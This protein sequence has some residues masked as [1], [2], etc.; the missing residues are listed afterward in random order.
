[1]IVGGNFGGKGA[2]AM[3]L[4]VRDA[5][6]ARFPGGTCCVPISQERSRAAY[7]AKGLVPVL[8]RAQTR[9]MRR[10]ER[11]LTVNRVFSPTP[12]DPISLNRSRRDVINAYRCSDAVID[13]RGF[14]GSDEFG[15]RPAIDRYTG[16]ELAAASGNRI[17]LMPQSWGPFKHPVVRDYVA[18]LLRLSDL[19]FAREH[20]SL[21]HLGELP[22]FDTSRVVHAPDIAFHF[23]GDPPEAGRMRLAELGVAIGERPVVGITPNMRIVERTSG[24]GAGNAYFR[25]LLGL[26]RWFLDHTDASLVLIPHEHTPGRANDP[27][28]CTAVA[29]A[30]GAPDRVASLTGLESA[31]TIKSVIGLLDFVVASRYHSLVAAISTRTPVAVIGWSHKYDELMQRAGLGEWVTDPAR[32][33]G[34]ATEELLIDAWRHRDEIRRSLEAHVPALEQDSR[35]ALDRML[36]ELARR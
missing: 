29:T 26:G 13:I 22:G 2:E 15:P 35:A 31:A 16:Y 11:W 33:P 1:M 36:D 14:S 34:A 3:M 21:A 25:S 6:R 23:Q 28:L 4:T 19:V 24:D 7:E 18:R 20:E 5:I 27:E 17:I 12:V 8:R 32:R 30:L 10:V 9:G